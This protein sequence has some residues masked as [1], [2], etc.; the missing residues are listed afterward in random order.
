ME[1]ILS[2]ICQKPLNDQEKVL[3]RD[4][5]SAGINTQAQKKDHS[6]R[7]IAGTLVL[8]KRKRKYT[9]VENSNNPPKADSAMHLTRLSTGGFDCLLC[10][11]CVTDKEKTEWQMR[12]VQCKNKKVDR[13]IADAIL[14]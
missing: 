4:K 8:T 14:S 10:S 7:V 2:P 12:M 11:R 6:L 3:L 9:K 13:A 5:G 1:K